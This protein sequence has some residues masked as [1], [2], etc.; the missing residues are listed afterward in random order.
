MSKTRPGHVVKSFRG[1]PPMYQC[2]S[3]AYSSTWYVMP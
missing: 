1:P 2:L 3:K